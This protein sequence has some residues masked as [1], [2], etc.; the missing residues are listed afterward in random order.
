MG[1]A[2]MRPFL[3]LVYEFNERVKQDFE[4]H[5]DCLFC[6]IAPTPL[7][8]AAVI[9]VIGTDRERPAAVH[10]YGVC[11]DCAELYGDG[12]ARALRIWWERYC[13]EYLPL[14]GVY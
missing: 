8:K 6:E 11:E 4:D 5:G 14:D 3:A 12:L 10:V 1:D 13:L 2:V 7:V 9:Q